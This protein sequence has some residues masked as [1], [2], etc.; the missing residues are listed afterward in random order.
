MINIEDVKKLQRMDDDDLMLI[1]KDYDLLGYNEAMRI[2]AIHILKTRGIA[3]EIPR[4]S[5]EEEI[6][7]LESQLF[8]QEA[9]E[10]Q[11]WDYIQFGILAGLGV[12]N[13][14]PHLYMESP[15]T[16]HLVL[17]MHVIT[18]IALVYLLKQRMN[19]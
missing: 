13:L 2:E 5:Q 11:K 7:R 12:V 10:E 15:L 14:V 16:N 8:L 19:T 17:V 4:E 9:L 6:E 1:A 3:V 18:L